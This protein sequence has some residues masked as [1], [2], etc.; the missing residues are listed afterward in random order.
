MSKVNKVIWITPPTLL[1][2]NNKEI[3]TSSGHKCSYCQGNGFF[4]EVQEDVKE[5]FKAACPVCRGSGKLRAAIII[6]WLPE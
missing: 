5:R 1:N 2:I 3:Q 6:E 4:W